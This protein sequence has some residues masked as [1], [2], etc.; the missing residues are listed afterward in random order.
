MTRRSAPFAAILAVTLIFG[1]PAAAQTAS[2]EA[3]AAARELVVVMRAAEQLKA[4]LPLIMQQ[5]KPAIV[6]GRPEVERDFDVMVPIMLDIANTRSAVMIEEVV[7]V[8]ARNFTAGEMQ[9]LIAFYRAPVGQK[10][11]E[12][13]PSVMQE[14]MAVGQKFGQSVAVE[15]RARVIEELR[16]RGHKI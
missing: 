5:L 7:A 9:Q 10:F 15:L 4:I 1:G 8:Y 2:P 6:Q 12:K 13:M 11:L 14:S 3:I 16:K